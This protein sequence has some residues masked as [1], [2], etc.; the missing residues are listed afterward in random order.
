MK[1]LLA[2]LAFRTERPLTAGSYVTTFDSS[3]AS[4][5][6]CRPSCRS[7]TAALRSGGW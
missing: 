3:T 2:V 5:G 1:C 4:P 6:W 7:R